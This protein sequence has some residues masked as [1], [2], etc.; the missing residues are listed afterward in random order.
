MNEQ[1]EKEYVTLILNVSKMTD[2]QE[3]LLWDFIEDGFDNR[4]LSLMRR[5][6]S[7]LLDDSEVK[8]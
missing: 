3:E 1:N 6:D 4:F 5:G 8:P 7:G 2:K